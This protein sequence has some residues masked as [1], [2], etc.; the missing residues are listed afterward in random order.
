MEKKHMNIRVLFVAVA[1]MCGTGK[2]YAT[3]QV[4]ERLIIGGVTNRLCTEPLS[5]YFTNTNTSPDDL[6]DGTNRL[7]CSACWRGYVGTW[8]IKD[9]FLWLLSLEQ[10]GGTPLELERIFPK[11]KAPIKAAWYSGNLRV[12][13]GKMLQYVHGGYA[14]RFEKDLFIKIENGRVIEQKVVDN[15]VAPASEETDGI[16]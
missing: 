16:E 15:T 4:A 1:L 3:A 10:W 11:Q 13:Q 7:V 5:P 6:F 14:S 12:T 2:A 9:G 8:E